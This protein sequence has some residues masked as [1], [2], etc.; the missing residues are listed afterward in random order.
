MTIII[1]TFLLL[2]FMLSQFYI[3]ASGTPQPFL[4]LFLTGIFI[5]LITRS[6]H[7]IPRV[8]AGSA[9][10]Y[11]L[12]ALVYAVVV[13][14]LWFMTLSSMNLL[15]SGVQMLVNLVIF[16]GFLV[17][18]RLPE[19]D[20]M[21]CSAG[22]AYTLI[23]SKAVLVAAFLA[24]FGRYSYFPRFNGFFND[25]NQMAYW[26]LCT[27]VIAALLTWKS[28]RLLIVNLVLSGAIISFSMS[29]S[30]TAAFFLIAI[31]VLIELWK[32]TRHKSITRFYIIFLGTAFT[33]IFAF[34]GI[35][36]QYFDLFENLAIMRRF[37]E[38]DVAE[39]LEERGYSRV[40]EFTEYILFGAGNGAHERFGTYLEIHSTL[41]GVLFYYGIVGGLPFT[42]GIS[43][44]IWRQKLTIK[45]IVLAPFVYGLSTYGYRTPVFWIMIASIIALIPRPYRKTVEV[46]YREYHPIRTK[47]NI[48][49]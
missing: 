45:L 5:L 37:A 8:K 9:E 11:I 43:A 49:K 14:I 13:D 10:W 38:I 36:E 30:A 40:T 31:A 46:R 42:I 1:K 12:A 15:A 6:S 28:T 39:S 23:F 32:R 22:V 17:I 3:L 4:F 21:N 35:I 7:I 20:K 48:F 24:G 2:G 27:F 47:E 44:S 33:I 25:P 34:S 26:S 18:F 41:V 16:F 29:R 19:Q